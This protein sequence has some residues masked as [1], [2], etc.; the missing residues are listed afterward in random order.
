MLNYL[1]PRFHYYSE[2]LPLLFKTVGLSILK[3]ASSIIMV[4]YK[5]ISHFTSSLKICRVFLSNNGRKARVGH[6]IVSQH[7]CHHYVN[8]YLKYQ[9]SSVGL[10]YNSACV[11]YHQ[12]YTYIF[13]LLL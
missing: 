3:I 13:P 5:H 7:H 6:I 12:N 8:V 2:I 9:P 10:Q 11:I 1:L 4:V